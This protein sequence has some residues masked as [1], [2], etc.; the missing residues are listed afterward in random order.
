MICLLILTIMSIVFRY[1]IFYYY[2]VDLFKDFDSALLYLFLF[3]LVILNKIIRFI[4]DTFFLSNNLLKPIQYD[5]YYLE[6]V[7]EESNIK[8]YNLNICKQEEI[9]EQYN[10]SESNSKEKAIK[11]S[12]GL[13][14]KI[15][16]NM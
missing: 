10:S 4:W 3:I 15:K 2:S 8:H 7:N 16:V 11:E 1:I 12:L 9:N 13:V 5:N 6:Q 14:F